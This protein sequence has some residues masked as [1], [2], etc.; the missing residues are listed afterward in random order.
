MV[1]YKIV[2]VDDES[3]ALVYLKKI[4][5]R[6]D[7][8]FEVAGTA[9]SAVMAVNVIQKTHPDVLITDIQ[10]PNCSGL[11]LLRPMGFTQ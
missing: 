9:S 5:S 10:L 6:T 8:W 4:F 3:W 1:M 11:E 2:L 7:L